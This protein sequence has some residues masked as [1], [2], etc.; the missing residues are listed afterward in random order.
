MLR[1]AFKQWR[2][3]ILEYVPARMVNGALEI[4]AIG[5]FDPS[6][7]T[8]AQSFGLCGTFGAER[9]LKLTFLRSAVSGTCPK[10]WSAQKYR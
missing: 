6:E 1:M 7:L 2:V 8:S 10:A 5:L 3:Q 9:S 4:G